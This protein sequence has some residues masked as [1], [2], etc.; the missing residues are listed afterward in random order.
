MRA[1]IATALG[2]SIP[3]ANAAAWYIGL[4]NV[5]VDPDQDTLTTIGTTQS[6][7]DSAQFS[8][9]R[10]A[11]LLTKGEHDLDIIV[12]YGMSVAGTGESPSDVTVNTVHSLDGGNAEHG[13]ATQNFWR[14]VEGLTVADDAVWA[15]SQAAPI[16]RMDF[17]GDLYL[18]ENGGY[19]SGG[20]LADSAVAGKVEFG[21]QQQYMVRSTSMGEAVYS[22]SGWNYVFAGSPGAPNSSDTSKPSMITT[23]ETVADGLAEKPYLVEKDG[24]WFVCVPSP[25]TKDSSGPSFLSPNDD[26]E[27]TLLAVG[28]SV[29][30]ADP[31]MNGTAINAGAV[32]K[33]GVLLT[34]GLYEMD[35]PLHVVEDD[36]VVLGIGFATLVSQRG[37]AAIVVADGLSNVRVASVLLESGSGID[38]TTATSPLLQ[39]GTTAV[40]SQAHATGN[41]LTDIF[42]RVGSFSYSREYKASC[43]VTRADVHVELNTAGLQVDNT[44]FWHADH[45]D[46]GG[47]SDDCVSGNG[48]VVNADNVTVYGLKSEHTMADLVSWKGEGGTTFLYQSELPY[49]DPSFGSEGFVGYH[50]DAT[51]STHT[52]YGIGCYIIGGELWNVKSGI[53]VPSTAEITNMLIL[54]IAGSLSQFDNL[55]CLTT[56][57]S[58]SSDDDVCYPGVDNQGIGVYQPSIHSLGSDDDGGSGTD[59]DGSNDGGGGGGD[60]DDDASGSSTYTDDCL[61]KSDSLTGVETMADGAYDSWQACAD[62]AVASGKGYWKWGATCGHWCSLIDVD[63]EGWPVEVNT[64]SQ[65]WVGTVPGNGACDYAQGERSRAARLG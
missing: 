33:S 54:V 11:V 20:H 14:S 57:G 62:A 52:G 7:I 34:P 12:G 22:S 55:I 38:E 29:F 8:D 28:D 58:E 24:D 21:T 16:R 2:A 31:S 40:Q 60:D 37:G 18:S 4:D 47:R 50:V 65:V 25:S 41:V 42:T 35:E 51:V 45:D 43:L 48:L 44:W 19:S 64:N 6:D 9:T 39:W 59:D 5:L 26:G 23:V 1:L 56:G 61:V 53:R 36:F 10:Y 17:K 13:G 15:A 46:C 27:A 63:N 49:Q 30:V 3:T 32:G